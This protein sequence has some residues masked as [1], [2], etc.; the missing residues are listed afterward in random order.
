MSVPKPC[1]LILLSKLRRRR[2]QKQKIQATINR[3]VISRWLNQLLLIYLK[4]LNQNSIQMLKKV[5]KRSKLTLMLVTKPIRLGQIFFRQMKV[6]NQIRLNKTHT[7][8]LQSSLQ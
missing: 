5:M 8:N 3:T 4:I 7:K 2:F 6:L 1:P